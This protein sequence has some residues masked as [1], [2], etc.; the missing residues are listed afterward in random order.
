MP[1]TFAFAA[2]DQVKVVPVRL[3]DKESPTDAPLH[4]VKL[5]ALVIVGEGFMTTSRVSFNPVQP[6]NEGVTTYCTV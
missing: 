3:P 2:A 5:E 4:I 6:L 1:V